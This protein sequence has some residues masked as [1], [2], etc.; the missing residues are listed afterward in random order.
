MIRKLNKGLKSLFSVFKLNGPA[1]SKIQGNHNNN[2]RPSERQVERQTER[3]V[4]RQVERQT[5]RAHKQVEVQPEFNSS[6]PQRKRKHKKKEFQEYRAPESRFPVLEEVPPKEGK[7][8]FIDFEVAPALLC[9]T[10]DLGFKY[11]TTIQEKAMPHALAGKD[12]TGKAQTGTGKTA[13]F[14]I[15]IMNGLLKEPKHGA[16]RGTCRALI[17]APTR[18]LAI[19]IHKDAEALAKFCK[20]KNAVVFGGMGHREQRRNLTSQATD[21]LVGTPGRIIDYSR[22]HDLDLSECEY[23][24]IDEADRMLDMGFIPDVKTIISKLPPTGERQ[25]MLFSATLDP[26][27]LKLAGQWLHE[28]VTV[29]VIPEHN[30]TDLITQKFY[31]VSVDEKLSLLLWFFKHAEVNRMLIFGNRKD[32]NER[33]AKNLAKNGIHCEILSGDVPQQKRMKILERFRSGETNVL[34]A[35]DVAARGIHVDS[36]SHVVNYDLPEKPEDY[37]HR[38][39]RTGRAGVKGEAINFV[40]EY[41]AFMLGSIEKVVGHKIKCIVPEENML[42][43]TP[44]DEE[45]MKHRDTRRSGGGFKRSR[46]QFDLNVRRKRHSSPRR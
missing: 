16:R 22:S 5:E 38:V 42:N 40:C 17:M 28:P 39:G 25:T 44:I 18:E 19:Q 14:L 12:I 36:I 1:D 2:V 29:E 27:I 4:E 33:L 34:V 31:S 37:I 15:T 45:K 24:V 11:C 21:I 10:Q 6:S 26:S 13:A 7:T 41:G 20:L 23:L 9:A 43:I 30:V 46:A 35:S 32:N 3:Q 8:R